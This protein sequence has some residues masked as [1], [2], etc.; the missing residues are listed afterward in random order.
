MK[1]YFLFITGVLLFALI[2]CNNSKTI[3]PFDMTLDGRKYER[4]FGHT[5]KL[6]IG[7]C[8]DAG[9]YEG[10]GVVDGKYFIPAKAGNGTHT[11]KTEDKDYIY[12]A[13]IK[14]FGGPPVVK[15]KPECSYCHGKDIVCPN[16]E[17]TDHRQ[18]CPEC[19]GEKIHKQKCEDCNG[20]GSGW[21][22]TCKTCSG[23]KQI[24]IKCSRCE[25]KGFLPCAK[26]GYADK[27]VC[28]R[29]N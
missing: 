7:G 10:K 26:C 8:G 21:L 5:Q 20:K 18:V 27:V 25:S 24:K 17:K 12:T 23:E 6:L 28:P 4:I 1:N 9:Q 14:V 11:I 3:K 16:K 15:P 19:N 22:R 13:D 2:G 29:C